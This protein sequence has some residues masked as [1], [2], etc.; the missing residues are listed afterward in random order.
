[1][2]GFCEV[3]SNLLFD[4]VGFCLFSAKIP[5][6][7]GS[8][9]TSLEQFLR[10]IWQAVPWVIV[11]SK[12]PTRN[13]TLKFQVMHFVFVFSQHRELILAQRRG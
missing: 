11:L 4:Y 3:C 1:M 6:Y 5:L 2:P 7:L 12:V 8:S 10:V 9:L 13:I